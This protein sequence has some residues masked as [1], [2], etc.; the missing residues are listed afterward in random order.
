MT[1]VVFVLPYFLPAVGGI[2]T[3]VL[4]LT[5]ELAKEGYE[6]EVH[7]SASSQRRANLFSEG[8]LNINKRYSV[9]YEKELLPR[10]VRQ[11]RNVKIPPDADIVH[12]HNFDRALVTSVLM[13]TL[14][15]KIPTL[16]TLHGALASIYERIIRYESLRE[17]L[18]IST[19]LFFDKVI[20]YNLLNYFNGIIALCHKEKDVLIQSINNPNIH[21]K[22]KIIPNFV[23]DVFFGLDIDVDLLDKNIKR[24]I[25]DYNENYIITIAR[26]SKE[27]RLD[28]VI[29]TLPKLSNIHYVIVG[30]DTGN[31]RQ[32]LNLANKLG[33][34]SR[35]HYLGTIYDIRT[36]IMLLKH[37]RIFVLP[38]KVEVFPMS[39]L[40]AMS[41]GLPVIATSAGCLPEI[42]E[43]YINGFLFSQL[44][45]FEKYIQIVIENERLRRYMGMKA[46]EKVLE[47]FSISKIIKK[48]KKLYDKVEEK[49]NEEME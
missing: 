19:K 21:K 10:F 12:I 11:I 18:R 17:Y 31:L 9:I 15:M 6:I 29:R 40:E 14:S 25:E 44:S 39:V 8:K 35:V 2:V 49:K 37:A 7:V 38:S 41:Q 48:L 42:V 23:P 24:I 47:K 32:L 5:R 1:K 45:E 28:I 3:H 27:K 33:V 34:R 26:I 16:I 36:K 30:P 46:Q 22:I 13:K 43:H 20:S 4:Y